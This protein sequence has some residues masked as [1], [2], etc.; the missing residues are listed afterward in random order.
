MNNVL[1][2]S[3]MIQLYLYE[4]NYI[5]YNLLS[6]HKI[7]KFILKTILHFKQQS[8]RLAQ[9]PSFYYFHELSPLRTS[10][11]ILVGKGVVM[12]RGVGVCNYIVVY[13]INIV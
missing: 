5:S 12:I 7:T 13:Y 11:L 4:R 10:S 9:V 6:F 3:L 1:K 8:T 2:Y